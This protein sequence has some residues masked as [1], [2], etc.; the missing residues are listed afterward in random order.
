MRIP[1]GRSPSTTTTDPVLRSSI[2]AEAAAM[3]SEDAAVTA[4]VLITS[5]TVRMVAGAGHGVG[6]YRGRPFAAAAGPTPTASVHPNRERLV[7]PRCAAGHS[8]ARRSCRCPRSP[9]SSGR[10]A[11]TVPLDERADG[12]RRAGTG[13]LA[14]RR[15]RAPARRVGPIAV[16]RRRPRRSA[17]ATPP[18]VPAAQLD[19]ALEQHAAHPDDRQGGHP[20][21]DRPTGPPRCR[22]RR[23][24][25]PPARS[26]A[27]G[28]VVGSV[29]RPSP[30][31]L[32][33]MQPARR[34]RGGRR[35]GVGSWGR[36]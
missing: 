30:R 25:R 8:A 2:R 6:S 9:P 18:D 32:N 4:G 7:T 15:P 1:I 24:A 10:S 35:A 31:R 23:A 16:R 34:P 19:P 3:V 28:S 13:G 12:A 29:L 22:R 11:T 26:R 20:R 14:H 33:R 36:R 17:P 21:A 27:G 5:A